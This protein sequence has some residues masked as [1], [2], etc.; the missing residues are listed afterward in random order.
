MFLPFFFL[1]FF[2]FFTRWPVGGWRNYKILLLFHFVFI[3]SF[4]IFF[5]LFCTFFRVF[6]L[7]LLLP[8]LWRRQRR[9]LRLLLLLLLSVL[10]FLLPVLYTLSQLYPGGEWWRTKPFVPAGDQRQELSF[11]PTCLATG[12]CHLCVYIPV[13]SPGSSVRLTSMRLRWSWCRSGRRS[14]R[15]SSR[16]TRGWCI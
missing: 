10:L 2:L 14:K 3:L 15:W 8:L 13:R 7:P 11:R 9:R 4:C 16:K 5:L 1:S 6:L 12:D